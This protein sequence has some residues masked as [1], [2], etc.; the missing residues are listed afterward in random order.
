[1]TPG[2]VPGSRSLPRHARW[3]SVPGPFEDAAAEGTRCCCKRAALPKCTSQPRLEQAVFLA[4]SS[5][6]NDSTTGPIRLCMRP[7][8]D[9]ELCAGLGDGADRP[10]WGY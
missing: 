8:L 3:A 9:A 7:G 4:D 1:M 2:E 5:P 6:V 10:E